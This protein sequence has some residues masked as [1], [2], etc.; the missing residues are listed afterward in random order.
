MQQNIVIWV[1]IDDS[2]VVDLL[3]NSNNKD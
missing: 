2:T 3:H 1:Y